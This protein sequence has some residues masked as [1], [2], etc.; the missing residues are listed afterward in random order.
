LLWLSPGGRGGD[1]G[2]GGEGGRGG[3]GGN[4]GEILY[5]K[6]LQA[7]VLAGRVTLQSNPGNDGQ[8][9]R[10]GPGGIG[11]LGGATGQGCGP[12]GPR[13]EPG[14]SD[15]FRSRSHLSVEES[16]KPTRGSIRCLDCQPPVER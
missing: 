10:P 4:G 15:W 8:N 6:A 7:L 12:Y 11:G 13:A 16:P 14:Y 3:K 9:G 1:G 5:S 2:A